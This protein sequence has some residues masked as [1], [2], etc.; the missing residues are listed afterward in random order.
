MQHTFG[1][2]TPKAQ[3]LILPGC[4][5]NKKKLLWDLLPMFVNTPRPEMS[6]LRLHWDNNLTFAEDYAAQL[7]GDTA[8]GQVCFKAS[9]SGRSPGRTNGPHTASLPVPDVS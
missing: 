8:D 2:Y 4:D 1:I 9:G 7:L 6:L 3:P 5:A